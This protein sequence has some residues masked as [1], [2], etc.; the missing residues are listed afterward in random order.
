[1]HVR[2]VR[3]FLLIALTVFVGGGAV[4][5]G[6]GGGRSALQGADGTGRYVIAS[7]GQ[8]GVYFPTAGKIQ[9]LGREVEPNLNLD[10]QTTG[11]SVANARLLQHGE[12]DF[13]MIQNDIAAYAREGRECSQR[14]ALFPRFGASRR[15]DPRTSRLSRTKRRASSA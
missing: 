11:G 10:V 6:G 12:A 2:P 5:C 1:M 3:L 4:G 14:V 9:E 15:R 8:S 13:A 7:G